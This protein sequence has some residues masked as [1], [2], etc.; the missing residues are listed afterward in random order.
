MTIDPSQVNGGSV[1]FGVAA[2]AGQDFPSYGNYNM[3]PGQIMAAAASD[4]GVRTS[5]S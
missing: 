5:S 4:P 2:P 3:T 1:D